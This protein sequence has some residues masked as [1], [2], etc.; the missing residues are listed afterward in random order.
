MYTEAVK[1]YTRKVND[2]KMAAPKIHEYIWKYLSPESQDK[3]KH[4]VDY[5]TFSVDKDPEK[6]WAAI[7]KT[8][9]VNSL[10]K[11]PEVLKQAAR[12]EYQSCRQEGC[13]SLITYRECFDAAA[14]SCK[15]QHNAVMSDLDIAMDFFK[16]LDPARYSQFKTD[17]QNGI[18]AGT[19]QAVTT[20]EEVN[21]VYEL[22][23]NWIKM[24]HVQRQGILATYVTTHLDKVEKKPR[25][26]KSCTALATQEQ[27]PKQTEKNETNEK[28]GKKKDVTCYN[29]QKKGHYANKCP[30][31]KK[32][33]ENEEES[34]MIHTL[35]A[36]WQASAYCT[37]TVNNAVNES[38][39]VGPN[40][41]LLDNQADISI[42]KVH[43]LE[44]VEQCDREIKIN[45]VGGLTLTMN[46]TGYLPDF[47]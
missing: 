26:E 45:K 42:I 24:Q 6:L 1:A 37:H 22:A 3:V 29:C 32:E 20:L 21:K 30:E 9:E 12:K 46:K 31:K 23:A 2:G 14:K 4:Q 7:V 33:T 13:E 38:L 35:N 17:I 36:T 8:H 43:L 18:T 40:E 28:N 25:A 19:I 39:K 41:V 5:V 44:N 47:F 11:I 16:G 15:D 10:S 27:Q 34:D